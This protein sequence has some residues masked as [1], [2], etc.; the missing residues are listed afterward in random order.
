MMTEDGFA[1]SS[2]SGAGGFLRFEPGFGLL[3]DIH[4]HTRSQLLYTH[5]HTPYKQ[6]AWKMTRKVGGGKRLR[7]ARHL[8]FDLGQINWAWVVSDRC[9]VEKWA[10]LGVRACARFLP[11]DEMTKRRWKTSQNRIWFGGRCWEGKFKKD[12]MMHTRLNWWKT[13]KTLTTRCRR[14]RADEQDDDDEKMNEKKKLENLYRY[15]KKKTVIKYDKNCISVWL[16]QYVWK[17]K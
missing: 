12:K 14:K 3:K 13:S 5:T 9:G 10:N 16:K 8:R 2:T 7:R 17:R 11:P 15:N 4:T 6:R 1:S